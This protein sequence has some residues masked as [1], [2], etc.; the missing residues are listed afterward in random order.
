MATTVELDAIQAEL[1]RLG[2]SSSETDGLTSHEWAEH[3]QISIHNARKTIREALRA[4][5]M[6]SAYGYRQG[7]MDGRMNRV[8]VYILVKKKRGRPPGKKKKA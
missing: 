6:Q 5:L 1:E 7:E 4:S 8:P 3:W 2:V